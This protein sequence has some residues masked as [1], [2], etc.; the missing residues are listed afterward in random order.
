MRRPELAIS[1]T[2]P[3]EIEAGGWTGVPESTGEDS[4]SVGGTVFAR[5][6]DADDEMRRIPSRV[7]Q[8]LARMSDDPLF[9][10]VGFSDAVGFSPTPWGSPIRDEESLYAPA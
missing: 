2:W 10:S 7:F 4:R 5:G 3:G 9:C 8:K 6:G 1:G